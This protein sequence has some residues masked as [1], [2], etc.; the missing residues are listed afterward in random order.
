MRAADGRSFLIE[1][2]SMRDILAAL[3]RNLEGQPIHLLL[4]TITEVPR[5]LWTV[6]YME[7]S[8]NLFLHS[9]ADTSSTFPAAS[10]IVARLL[11]MDRHKPQLKNRSRECSEIYQ[12]YWQTPL[13]KMAPFP[14]ILLWNICIYP[15]VNANLMQPF[16]E[17]LHHESCQQTENTLRYIM[18]V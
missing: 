12:Q 10:R 5:L 17:C 9:S 7:I 13:R 3:S 2:R 8:T 14:C 15:V 11:W 16:V 18:T 1:L 4:V 6:Q